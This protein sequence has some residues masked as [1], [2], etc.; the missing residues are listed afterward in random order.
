MIFG[1]LGDLPLRDPDEGRNAEIAREMLAT[2]EWL[3]PT[4]NGL[5]YLDKPAFFF[6]AVALAFSIFGENEF[7]ARLPSALAAC[8]ILLMVYR[9]CRR[10]YDSETAALAVVVVATTPLFFAM[11][12]HVM[13]DMILAFFVCGAICSGYIAEQHEAARRRNW[14]LL[15]AAAAG[16]A[17]LVKGPVG[18]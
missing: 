1:R 8:G 12:R 7:A 2:G 4:Y 16:F 5:V 18:F 11:A 15:A 14:Y 13:S 9:F 6:R 3:T 10:D 17:T